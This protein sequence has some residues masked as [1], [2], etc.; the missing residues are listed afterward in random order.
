MFRIL[1]LSHLLIQA[2]SAWARFPILMGAKQRILDQAVKENFTVIAFA[3]DIAC[4]GKREQHQIAAEWLA[5]FRL[6][7]SGL[8]MD[9]NELLFVPGNH[10]INGAMISFVDAP[11]AS[12]VLPK[13]SEVKCSTSMRSF[14]AIVLKSVRQPRSPIET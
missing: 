11:A 12:F 6:G 10:D 13:Y 5:G 4:S 14:S 9:R 1:H 2:K 3:G 8:N 7:T